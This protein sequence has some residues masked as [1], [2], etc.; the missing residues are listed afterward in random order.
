MKKL[1]EFP[2]VI[3]DKIQK[4]ANKHHNGNF[5]KATVDICG[6]ATKEAKKNEK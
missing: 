3:A 4:Y 5:T 1:I 2:K 6:N